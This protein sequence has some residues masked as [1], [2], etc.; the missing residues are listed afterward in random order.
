MHRHLASTGL[1]AIVFT[2]VSLVSVSLSAQTPAS[3]PGQGPAESTW[4]ARMPWGD[5]DLQGMWSYATL[6]PLERPTEMGDREYL[7]DEEV[8]ARDAGS[9]IDRQPRPG[10]T[11]NYNRFWFDQGSASTRTS[12]II[13]PPTGRLPPMTP[14]ARKR[15][16]RRRRLRS[17][18]YV[19]DS[20]LDLQTDDRC[21]MY[22]GVPPQPS[23]YNNTWQLLQTPG[24]VVIRAE[25][26]HDVRF[27]S[28]DDRSHLP[29][30]IRQWNGNSIGHW[31]G[32]T[33]VVET[34]NY[35]EKTELRYP[36][37]L[38]GFHH[39]RAIERF[40]RVDADTIDYQFTIED[41]TVYTKPWTALLPLTNLHDYLMYEYACH[42]G[43][44]AMVNILSGARQAN[45]EER[46]SRR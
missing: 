36:L 31:E 23:G 45:L 28:I 1:P 39:A 3:Q 44:Y 6:T 20:W 42:E 17:D 18:G 37:Q 24:L 26:I 12:Q 8:A 4:T 11:G 34:T 7:T 16:D 25:N 19:P 9:V 22:H 29:S 21:I 15:L 41:P 38:E 35:S 40:T 27:I 13:D 10:D 33:L 5:P 14:D 43:N 32:D 30:G 2:F 46:G